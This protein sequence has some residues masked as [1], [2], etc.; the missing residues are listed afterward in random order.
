MISPIKRMTSA[1]SSAGDRSSRFP[2]GDIPLQN[3][4]SLYAESPD[5]LIF[6][7]AVSPRP[8]TA[9][10]SKTSAA[11]TFAPITIKDTK[12]WTNRDF[13]RIRNRKDSQHPRADGLTIRSRGVVCVA[14]SWSSRT[15]MRGEGRHPMA[16]HKVRVDGCNGACAAPS[17]GMGMVRC[18]P[19]S[20]P[21]GS[22]S[23]MTPLRR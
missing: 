14:S 22:G 6:T 7:R 5:L 19:E 17:S 9:A 10:A 8:P 13:L 12:S 20:G 2:G 15:P 21:R 11:R 1:F 4:K 16:I 18:T 23:R 3:L